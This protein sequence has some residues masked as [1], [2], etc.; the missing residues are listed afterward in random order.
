[1][2]KVPFSVSQFPRLEDFIC[3]ISLTLVH[4]GVIA[5]DGHLYERKEITAWLKIKKDSPKTKEVLKDELIHSV[6][7]KNARNILLKDYALLTY[8]EF[9]DIVKSGDV[10][11]FEYLDYLDVYLEH[12]Y[13]GDPCV[14]SQIIKDKKIEMLEYLLGNGLNPSTTFSNGSFPLRQALTVSK[15]VCEILLANGANIFASR[16]KDQW[17][18]LDFAIATRSINVDIFDLLIKKS[19]E[20]LVK[21]PSNT[22]KHSC[23][24]RAVQFEKYK[25]EYFLSN[26]FDINTLNAK[27]ETALHILCADTNNS[28]RPQ[29]AG[30]ILELLLQKGANILSKDG[31]GKTPIDHA[32][33]ANNQILIDKMESFIRNTQIQNENLKRNCAGLEATINTLETII[34]ATKKPKLSLRQSSPG[35]FQLTHKPKD[36]A[37]ELKRL[38]M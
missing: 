31:E 1:M 24:H 33:A 11:R 14:I 34:Q 35:L 29:E 2:P 28:K 17:S 30:E 38:K 4:D 27:K 21:E 18:V 19:Q 13:D 5:S 9:V 8:N 25:V 22:L 6:S 12:L 36:D 3:P 20:K 37:R 32:K 23:L 16:E 10:K 15:H 26:G 7:I